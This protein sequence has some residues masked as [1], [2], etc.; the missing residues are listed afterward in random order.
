LWDREVPGSEFE[1]Y[2][3]IDGRKITV[4]DLIDMFS[5]FEGWNFRL[6]ILDPSENLDE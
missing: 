4:E 3:E 6:Q 5:A 2:F 1:R